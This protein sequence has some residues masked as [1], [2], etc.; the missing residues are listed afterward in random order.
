MMAMITIV[1]NKIKILKFHFFYVQC[2]KSGLHF[3]PNLRMK[4]WAGWRTEMIHLFQ[5]CLSL[6]KSFVFFYRGFYQIG[7]FADWCWGNYC[8]EC[9]SA[10]HHIAGIVMRFGLFRF[11]YVRR[12]SGLRCAPNLRMK[13]WVDWRTEFFKELL[14]NYDMKHVWPPFLWPATRPEPNIK[15]N[16]IGSL[17]TVPWIQMYFHY[18]YSC[19]YPMVS[20][21]RSHSQYDA[22]SCTH[23]QRRQTISSAGQLNPRYYRIFRK[24]WSGYYCWVG[25]SKSKKKVHALWLTSLTCSAYLTRS[26]TRPVEQQSML[27]IWQNRRQ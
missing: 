6:R 22:Y 19:A 13:V 14:M 18:L 1:S 21:E 12:S 20:L 8:A 15:P 16:Y 4:V 25:N 26:S 3:V 11:F 17:A 5:Y 23:Y 9:R 2:S 24:G 7:I 10:N 27:Q